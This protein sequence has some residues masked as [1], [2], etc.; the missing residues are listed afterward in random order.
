MKQL[1]DRQKAKIVDALKNIELPSSFTY[2]MHKPEAVVYDLMF[3][4]LTYN[5]PLKP[6]RPEWRWSKVVGYRLR[7]S[8]IVYYNVYKQSDEAALLG[9]VCHECLHILQYGHG[10]NAIH[11]WNI[12][13]KMQ[14]ANYYI[15]GAVKEYIRR[16]DG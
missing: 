2:T 11:W 6:Y 8:N 1:T 15:G 14:S 5:V 16:N 9:L 13:R 12:K 10:G 7:G 4:I 3:Y